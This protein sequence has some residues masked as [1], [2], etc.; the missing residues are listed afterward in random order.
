VLRKVDRQVR[1]LPL[2]PSLKIAVKMRLIVNPKVVLSSFIENNADRKDLR[3]SLSESARETHHD[4]PTSARA[5]HSME[6]YRNMEQYCRNIESQNRELQEYIKKCQAALTC[7]K[8]KLAE[9]G[10]CAAGLQ[11]RLE[12]ASNTIFRLRPQRQECTESEIEEDYR[13]LIKLVKNWVSVNCESFVDDD[14]RGFDTIGSGRSGPAAHLE[15]CEAIISQFQSESSRWIEAKEH[16]IAAVVMRYL[17]DRVLNQSFS[18]L[19]DDQEQH[20]LATIQSS[21][22]NME[23]QKGELQAPET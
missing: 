6:Q 7:Y 9:S 3:R 13:K 14:L 20:F 18:V 5:Q 12:E 10:A 4:A 17:F 23:V 2:A 15:T 21:M 11:Q 19:L 8:S 16:V 1:V 22:E